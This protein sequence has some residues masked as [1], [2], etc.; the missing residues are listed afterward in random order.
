MNEFVGFPDE[1]EGMG[2][3]T[4][5][6]RPANSASEKVQECKCGQYWYNQSKCCDNP[7]L[8]WRVLPSEITCL[9]WCELEKIRLANKGTR[10]EVV[11]SPATE[12][13]KEGAYVALFSE[14]VRAVDVSDEEKEMEK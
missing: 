9:R 8:T 13:Y 10:S 7:E 11:Y 12:N 4:V 3:L 1:H 14:S 6:K 2:K 5:W